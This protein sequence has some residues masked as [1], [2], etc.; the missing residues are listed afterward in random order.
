[1]SQQKKTDS[2]NANDLTRI[3]TDDGLAQ[4]G[5]SLLNFAFSMALT[6]RTG[7]PTGT[8]VPDKV[9]AEAA[10]QAGLRKHLPKR[11]GRG[12]VANSVEALLGF[13]WLRHQITLDDILDCL[14]TDDTQPSQ[15]FAKLAQLALTRLER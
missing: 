4:L 13:V 11:V 15:S 5:D 10:V 7:M 1:M 12:D 3:L 2:Q 6:Q 9:L 8:R 14:K